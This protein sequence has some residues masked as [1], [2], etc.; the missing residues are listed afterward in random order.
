MILTCM[1][2]HLKI[3]L[4]NEKTV[5]ASI[6]TD[7]TLLKRMQAGLRAH[8]PPHPASPPVQHFASSSSLVV[9]PYAGIMTQ[10]NDLSVNITSSTEKI[11]A[12]QEALRNKHHN[13]MSYVCSSI[14]YPQR[15]NDY[16]FSKHDWPVLIQMLMCSLFLRLV[17]HSIHGLLLRILPK[18]IILLLSMLLILMRKMFEP[19]LFDE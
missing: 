16:N 14:R 11:L 19:T 15:C 17:L 12:S 8:A 5:T 9:D 1:F 13:D 2:K 6:D 18:P 3:D 7:R 10:L 4:S